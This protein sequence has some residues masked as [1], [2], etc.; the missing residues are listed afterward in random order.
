M[1]FG[2]GAFTV[3]DLKLDNL[4][5][6]RSH[7]LK[8]H[9]PHP[10]TTVLILEPWAVNVLWYCNNTQNV[11]FT[12]VLLNKLH[13]NQ[14][15]RAKLGP[16]GKKMLQQSQY[17]A[18]PRRIDTGRCIGLKVWLKVLRRWTKTGSH[19]IQHRPSC[20][21]HHVNPSTLPRTRR[22]THAARGQN[23]LRVK[24]MSNVLHR[25]LRKLLLKLRPD[26]E[27]SI[28]FTVGPWMFLSV[29]KAGDSGI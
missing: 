26:T 13:K 21:L 3:C 28:R 14:G 1:K 27:M 6:N 23:V 20:G 12:W 18:G 9:H 2:N 25:A 19:F 15:F 22:A 10:H 17:Y 5:L 24:V 11:E 8:S 29:P 7:S 16:Y 4:S